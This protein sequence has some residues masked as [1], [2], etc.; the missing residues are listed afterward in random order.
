MPGAASA[1]SLPRPGE[2]QDGARLRRV[3]LG[4]RARY[5]LE[6][7]RAVSGA[8]LESLGRLP[9]D[10]ARRAIREIPGVGDKVGDC[11]LL[12][13]LGFGEAFPVDVWIRRAMRRAYPRLRRAGDRAIAD[14]A[15]ARFG[16]RAGLAQQYLYVL[17]RD[18][19]LP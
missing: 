1:W 16:P 6:A 8:W 7:G 3:R 18:L 17:A 19:R 9:F 15:A 11:I 10:E 4:W 13:A 2:I 5:V 14:L 12:F